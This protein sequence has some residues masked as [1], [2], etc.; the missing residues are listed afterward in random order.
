[1]K[2]IFFLSVLTLTLFFSC[3]NE[4]KV[5]PKKMVATHIDSLQ[6]VAEITLMRKQVDSVLT[7]Q[8]GQCDTCV[9][10]YKAVI[11][12]N[13]LLTAKLS[14]QN[15]LMQKLILH[16]DSILKVSKMASPTILTA[17]R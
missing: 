15:Y 2:S 6:K 12:N 11:I 4:Q 7:F 1:M 10:S 3:L 8:A 17:S 5:S 14:E 9:E 16:N 13:R